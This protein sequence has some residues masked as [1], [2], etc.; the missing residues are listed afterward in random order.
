[1]EV[2]TGKAEN[3]TLTVIQTLYAQVYVNVHWGCK[4]YVHIF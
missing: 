1:M 3:G 4:M 2:R